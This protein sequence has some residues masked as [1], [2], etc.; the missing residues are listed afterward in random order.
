V[1]S[2]FSFQPVVLFTLIGQEY[3]GKTIVTASPDKTAKLWDLKG[4]L[5]ADIKGHTGWVTSAVFSPDGKYILTASDD[6][7]V[8]IWPM[9]ET[10]MEWLK[11]APIPKLTKQEK[12][13]LG[14]EGLLK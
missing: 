11:T 9:P 3:N 14:I 8:I 12:K 5:L 1:G 10:I 2:F 6:G 7:T 4:N 13:E